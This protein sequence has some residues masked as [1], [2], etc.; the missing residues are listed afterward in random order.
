MYH[1]LRYSCTVIH[2]LQ[3]LV[4]VDPI[5]PFVLQHSVLAI[6]VFVDPIQPFVQ[7]VYDDY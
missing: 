6:I 3:L 5:Q 1:W 4:F 2:V 7:Y